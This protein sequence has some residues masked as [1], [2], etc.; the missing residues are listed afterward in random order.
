MQRVKV[1]STMTLV[2]AI[3]LAGCAVSHNVDHLPDQSD[4]A[5]VDEAV[6]FS[7]VSSWTPPSP[8]SSDPLS[9][10]GA[11]SE[12]TGLRFKFHI[13]AQDG[14]TKLSLMLVSGDKLPDVM[15]ITN[16]VM[17][18]KLIEAGKVWNLEEFLTKYDP[19]S[20]LLTD[21]PEDMKEVISERDGGWYAYPSHISTVDAR[22][23]YPPSSDYYEIGIK[24]RKNF[25]IMI[26]QKILD[27]LGLTLEDVGTESGLTAAYRM[28]A[29]SKLAIGGEPVI[30]LQVEGRL[31][32][33]TTLATLQDMFGVMAVD[34]NGVY[35]DRLLA[36]ET[37][38][39]LR[40][41]NHAIREAYISPGQL[42]LDLTAVKSA[43]MSGRVFSFIGNTANT[44]LSEKDYWVSPGPI[45]SNE[46]TKPVLGVSKK[47]GSGWMQTYI[48]KSTEFPEKL[49]KWL[50]YMTSD[51]G[52][53]LQ[54]FGFEG[55]HYKKNEQG[56]VVQTDAGVQAIENFAATGVGAFW[57]F[58]NISWNDSVKQA[59]VTKTGTDGLVA[60][61]VQTAF[62]R[63]PHTFIYD[64]APLLLPADFIP[65]GSEMFHVQEQ[66]EVYKEAQISKIVMARDDKEFDRLYNELIA[67]V[68]ALGIEAIDKKINEQV[69]KQKEESGVELKGVNS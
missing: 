55:R 35:R 21:F 52:M 63:S 17:A 37:K 29:D 14:A 62:G 50:S 18:K 53:L 64:Y 41:L 27:E 28:L 39:A 4:R 60:M 8:W 46:G 33:D 44:G 26:N 38:H 5:G 59:P 32:Q 12:K 66:I 1:L 45:L 61:N 40:F 23:Q 30:P 16:L 65:S 42:T 51:E 3:L 13:P 9:V 67:T 6:W 11:I 57:S 36:P 68:K 54:H 49:A 47:P 69:Q 10:E 7:D 15:T 20:H 56:L 48:S 34:K 25:G 58:A 22:K 43:T 31:Y 19:S 24:Y 2:L